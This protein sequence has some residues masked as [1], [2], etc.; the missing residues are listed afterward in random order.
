MDSGLE[1]FALR[2][3]PRA[4]RMVADALEGKGYEPF[5]PLHRERRRWSDRVKTVEAPLFAGYV[6]CR[7]DVQRRLGVL[8]TPGVLHVVSTGS[9]PQPIAPEEIDSLRVV[10]RSGLQLESWPHLHVGQRICIV[11]G[12]LAGA[13]GTLQ[14]VKA[15]DRLVVSVS[16]LQRS[17]SV[18]IPEECA[19]PATA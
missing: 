12:P 10:V 11:S 5:L 19:W 9:V 17:V 18:V 3:R 8:T 4:E 6:F 1:W 15:Q 7:F 2:V 13:T 16:L 14:S